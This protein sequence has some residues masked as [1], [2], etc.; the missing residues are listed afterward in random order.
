VFHF[1]CGLLFEK[2]RKFL[3]VETADA[4]G[5]IDVEVPMDGI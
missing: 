5:S 3:A 2:F 1:T 4:G